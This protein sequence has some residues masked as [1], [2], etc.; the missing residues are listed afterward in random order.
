MNLRTGRDIRFIQ[1]IQ[2]CLIPLIPQN[3]KKKVTYS[4]EFIHRSTGFD[5]ELAWSAIWL[6][7]AT[8]EQVYMD[9]ALEFYNSGVQWAY[10]WDA[11]MAG[12]QVRNILCL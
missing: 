10:S 2:Y 1:Y 7:I 9:R 12:V 5:D 6:Y 11:K 3:K 8:N 4:S